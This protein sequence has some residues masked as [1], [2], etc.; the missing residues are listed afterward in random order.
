M[1]YLFIFA[2][3]LGLAPT[4]CA[5]AKPHVMSFGKLSTVKLLLGPSEEKALTISVRPLY[6]DIKLKEYV[7]GPVHEI[8][9]RVFVVRRAYRV[10]DSL[11]TESAARWLWQRGGWLLVDRNTG[12]ITQ[13]KLPDFDPYYSDVSWYRD[14]AAYCGVADDGNRVSAMVVQVTAKKPLYK[15]QLEKLGGEFPD[16]VCEAPLWQR[17]PIRVTF[18]PLGGDKL[19][20]DVNGRFADVTPDSPG[21][22]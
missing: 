20:V 14:Y 11:P 3:I 9:D 17:M 4:S 15:K 12:R 7:T 22:E 13:L 18:A 1:R 6:L 21:E 8:T 5:A 10:N 19:S 16:A 2:A